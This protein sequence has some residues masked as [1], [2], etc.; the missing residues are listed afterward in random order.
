MKN[1][2]LTI[3]T[4]L[5]LAVVAYAEEELRV[6]NF[7]DIKLQSTNKGSK[8]YFD[9]LL[10]RLQSND[11]TLTGR[12]YQYLYFGYMYQED[13]D[14]YR[15]NDVPEDIQGMYS[16]IE[17]LNKADTR[18]VLN[19]TKRALAN[20][21]FDLMMRYNLCQ[22]YR[23]MGK[24]NLAAC[25]E[26]HLHKLVH[27]ITSSGDG[28]RENPFYVI[29]PANEYALLNL[30]NYTVTEVN[31]SEDGDLDIV[32]VEGNTHHTTRTFYFNVAECLRIDAIKFDESEE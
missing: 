17:D 9:R 13:F 23:K 15:E 32:K 28:S 3:F 8:L 20:N 18:E 16:H 27:V 26:A 2:L 10:D 19:C 11:T 7:K 21:P 5:S 14:T 4:I 31:S 30:L 1:L 12:E 6:P 22:I 29:S 24:E 25:Q